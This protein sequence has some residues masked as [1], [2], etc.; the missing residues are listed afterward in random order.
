[1]TDS[2]TVWIRTAKHGSPLA[3]YHTDRQCRNAMRANH[4]REITLGRAESRGLEECK[5]CSGDLS[6]SDTRPDKYTRLIE[7]AAVEG[8]D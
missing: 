6:P 7:G 4:I 8:G 1:M 5:V 3:H 2:E